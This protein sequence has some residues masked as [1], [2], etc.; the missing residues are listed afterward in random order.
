[1]V[2]CGIIGASAKGDTN[3]DTNWRSKIKVEHE[4]AQKTGILAI[5]GFVP[6]RSAIRLCLRKA[7]IFP[8]LLVLQ[9]DC[10]L[11]FNFLYL[12]YI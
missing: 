4:Q 1:L 2:W 12:F 7:A 8:L 3:S 10:A 6:I 9:Q 5:S 11:V